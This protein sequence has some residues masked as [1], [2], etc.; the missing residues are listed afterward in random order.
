MCFGVNNQWRYLAAVLLLCGGAW[1][2]SSPVRLPGLARV[3]DTDVSG[4]TWRESGETAGGLVVARG[5]FE[6]CLTAQGWR[7]ERNIPLGTGRSGSL[8]QQWCRGNERMMLM[9]WEASTGKTGFSWGLVGNQEKKK[10]Q[11]P[12][13]S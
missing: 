13:R 9:L 3:L 12:R 8:L 4:D 10:T 1:A 11:K 2:A 7:F 6:R 5:D